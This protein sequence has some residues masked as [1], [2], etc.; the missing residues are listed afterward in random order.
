MKIFY[1]TAATRCYLLV[2]TL[3]DVAPAASHPAAEYCCFVVI[4]DDGTA[5]L[6][7]LLLAATGSYREVT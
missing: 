7:L 5:L 1:I 6:L 3:I 4:A 2:A